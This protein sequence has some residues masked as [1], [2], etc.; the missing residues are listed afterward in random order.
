MNMENTCNLVSEGIESR[1]VVVCQVCN[2]QMDYLSAMASQ[3]VEN[4]IYFCVESLK[5]KIF[6]YG[7]Y[8]GGKYGALTHAQY[9]TKEECKNKVCE[10]AISSILTG[11]ND[12]EYSRHINCSKGNMDAVIL[13]KNMI[14]TR[15]YDLLNDQLK[16][17]FNEPRG[18]KK[19]FCHEHASINDFK[20]SCGENLIPLG[21][22]RHRKLIGMEDQD[23]IETV[24][25]AILLL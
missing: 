22:E 14:E 23:F 5:Q 3:G 25:P 15:K 19:Y 10:E 24:I 17:I 9:F 6:V 16:D 7:R 1:D 18:D 8:V 12:E 2:K 21:S 11:R 20:C 13:T 4:A